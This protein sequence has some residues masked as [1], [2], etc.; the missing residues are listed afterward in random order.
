MSSHAKHEIKS[1][2]YHE[3]GMK[4]DDSLELAE[5]EKHEYNGA[6]S[7]LAA[8][9]KSVEGLTANVDKELLEA[10]IDGDQAALIKKWLIRAVNVVQN[11]GLQAEVQSHIAQGK[12]VA[13]TAAV[14]QAKSLYDAEKA[15]MEA[16]E[17]QEAGGE[18]QV[19]EDPRRPVARPVGQHPGNPIAERKLAE[20][21]AVEGEASE[22]VLVP[23]PKKRS[24]RKDA[25]NT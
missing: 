11:L 3:I 2:V 6:K 13:L 16:L 14:K 18:G 10:Q 22:T 7:V 23:S 1:L 15:R 17:V 24:K 19:E 4:L 5:R 21:A 9:R 20:K 25:E 12:I 8:A